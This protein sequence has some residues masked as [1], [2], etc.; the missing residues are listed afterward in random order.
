[1]ASGLFIYFLQYFEGTQ[2]CNKRNSCSRVEQKRYEIRVG[3][4]PRERALIMVCLSE[5][6]HMSSIIT[7]LC[8]TVGGYLDNNKKNNKKKQL[9]VL[10][11][12]HEIWVHNM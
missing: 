8:M 2:V 9:S 12:I 10:L 3:E 7:H 6:S 4:L 11:G 5:D 1:M